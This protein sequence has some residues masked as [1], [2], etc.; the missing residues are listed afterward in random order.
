MEGKF[1]STEVLAVSIWDQIEAD[2]RIYG[3]E[4]HAVKLFES[5]NNYAEYFGK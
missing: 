3:A 1:A 4:L 5:E 2:I